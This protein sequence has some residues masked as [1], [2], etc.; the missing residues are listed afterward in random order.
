MV[1]SDSRQRQQINVKL[2]H[3]TDELI[4]LNNCQTKTIWSQ[5]FKVKFLREKNCGPIKNH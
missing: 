1:I 5:K 4:K 3:L 2:W